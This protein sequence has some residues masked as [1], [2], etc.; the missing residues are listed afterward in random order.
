MDYAEL[1]LPPALDG[2]VA[3]LWTATVTGDAEWTGYEAAPDGCVELIRRHSGRSIWRSEQPPLFATGLNTRPVALQLGRG[4]RFTGI[5]LWPWAW[6]ALG[7]AACT[8]FFDRWIA[9]DEATPLAALLP[10][11]SALAVARLEAGFAALPPPPLRVVLGAQSV[12]EIARRTGL[13]PRA[14]QRRFAREIGL[15][16]RSYLRFVRFRDAMLGVQ[17]GQ[18]PLADTAAA[19]GFADQA[20]MTRE[21]R[22]LAGVPPGEARTRARG[23][24]V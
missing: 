8:G 9:I 15:P 23:P 14:L 21:F 13:A 3:A 4:A 7:G 16:P 10:E 18:E 24:F 2:L 20:H 17:A 11:D 22:A 12:A 19:Q 1:P 6:H 5:K